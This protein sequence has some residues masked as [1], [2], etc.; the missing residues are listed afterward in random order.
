MAVRWDP[1]VS[2]PSGSTQA[3]CPS[4]C[5][6]S[7][8]SISTASTP[9]AKASHMAKVG[10]KGGAECLPEWRTLQDFL[11]KGMD[12]MKRWLNWGLDL[13]SLQQTVR[14]NWGNKKESV[15]DDSSDMIQS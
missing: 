12:T 6:G 10:V 7:S 9:L 14:L 3:L 2:S 8:T 11:A 1:Q 13:I 4:N 5:R 15:E